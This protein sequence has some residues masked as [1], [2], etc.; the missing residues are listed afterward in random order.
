L[1]ATCRAPQDALE[2]GPFDVALELVGGPSF[3]AVLNNLAPWG[4]VVV[5]GTGAG[6]RAEINLH[7]LME[8][9]ATVRGSTLRSRSLEEKALVTRLVE[10]H[11]LPLVA[12]NR[13]QVLV[14]A[15]F[16]FEAAQEAYDRFA[17]GGKLGKIVL[18]PGPA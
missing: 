13:A 1:G 4:R 9:R 6:G 14:S 12:G 15:V 8:R 2:L 17:A 10:R 3:P 7:A 16:P 18:V 11:V 5:I